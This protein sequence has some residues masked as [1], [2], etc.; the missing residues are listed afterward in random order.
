MGLCYKCF[1][2]S[3]ASDRDFCFAEELLPCMKG[4]SELMDSVLR[5]LEA[6]SSGLPSK[7]VLACSSSQAKLF[8]RC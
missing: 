2:A 6:Q 1:E 3:Q 7:V 8:P 5:G 4:K